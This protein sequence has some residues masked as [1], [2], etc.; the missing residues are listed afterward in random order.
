MRPGTIIFI[1]VLFIFSGVIAFS[2]QN[3]GAK[4][5]DLD[6]GKR[7]II[8]F[9]HHLHHGA[10]KECNTCHAVFPKA[11]E[12]IKTLKTRGELKKKQVMNKTC[13][14]CHRAMKKAGEKTGP[15]KCSAC[16]VKKG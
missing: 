5:I 14:K 8:N 11:K 1:L 3:F 16:H 15:T 10:V 12:S 6:G 9:P 7:G 2:A 13:L 4:D